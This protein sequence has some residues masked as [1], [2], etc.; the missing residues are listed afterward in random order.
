MTAKKNSAHGTSKDI[1][2][3]FNIPPKQGIRT[4]WNLWWESW[5]ALKSGRWVTFQLWTEPKKDKTRC[6]YHQISNY[7]FLYTPYPCSYEDPN[8]VWSV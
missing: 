6:N 4:A 8:C 7:P 5:K 2:A 3:S 1:T